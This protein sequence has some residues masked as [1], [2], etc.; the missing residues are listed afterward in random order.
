MHEVIFG[1]DARI[2]SGV[3]LVAVFV[4]LVTERLH[5]TMVAALTALLL[6]LAGVLT[7]EQAVEGIDFNTIGLL[8]GMMM[9]VGIARKSGMFEYLAIYA[10]KRVDADPRRLLMV[11]AVLTAVLSSL[12]D[13]VTTVL[14]TVPVT[15]LI[16]EKLRV[17]SFPFLFSAIFA[18]NIGGAATLIGDPPNI[19][20]G[21]A[22]GFTFTDFLMNVGP[23]CLANLI[24]MILVLDILWGRKLQAP[25]S[26]REW[27]MRFEEQ[28]ALRD[29][30][31]VWQS[32]IVL[33]LTILG[34]ILAEPLGLE[35]ATVALAGGG[36]LLFLRIVARP[37]ERQNKRVSESLEQIEWPTLAFFAALFVVVAGAEHSGL[38]T[39]VGEGLL[40]VTDG[41][42]QKTVFTV[43]WTAALAS[44]FMDNIPFV[45]TMIPLIEIASAQIASAHHVDAVWWALSLG[46]CLG[47]NG[48]L[49]GAAANVMVSS[50]AERN[51][52]PIGFRRF[53]VYAIP[54][55][56]LSILMSSA[57]LWARYFAAG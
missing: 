17:P 6:V 16:A 38:L 43:L 47:G 31:L 24:I 42:P 56:L 39:L 49:I 25:E 11:M 48:S 33:G 15:L 46:A 41:D 29:A 22:T 57:Y 45:A 2:V 40:A 12:L 1:L 4:L 50:I 55:M 18:S 13:N 14:L 23:V 44:A 54:M 7:Q 9:L 30:K 53:M 21:S 26:Q 19:L 36:L 35:A 34:F 8:A 37:I 20:I 27:V 28:D 51:G 5:R 32:V 3:A 10:A 52:E